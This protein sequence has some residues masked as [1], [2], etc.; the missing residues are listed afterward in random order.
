M[1][2]R[3]A[4]LVL[5][6]VALAARGAPGAD[7]VATVGST[8]ET[9]GLE[10][11]GRFVVRT[12]SILRPGIDQ[13]VPPNALAAMA[14]YDRILEIPT[15]A[16]NRAEALR[17]AADLRVQRADI[18]GEINLPL[19]RKAIALYQALLRE[20]PD[21]PYND[22]ALYQLARAQQAVGEVD[23]AIASLQALGQR[24]PQSIRTP[25][26]VFR[27]CRTA[28]SAQPLCRGRGRLP[29][30][31]GARAVDPVLRTGAVQVRLVAGASGALRRRHHAVLRDP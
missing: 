14:Q 6:A 8:T 11:N 4:L 19:L 20:S 29:S 12:P 1:N 31:A 9:N 16:A 18:D 24:Y 15:S 25:D 10:R 27:A 22:R 3:H 21:H 28:V 30:S 13:R 23:A 5:L 17:R 26:G 2:R 7:P